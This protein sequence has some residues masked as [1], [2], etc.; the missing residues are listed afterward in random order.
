M[1]LLVILL[2]IITFSSAH[3]INLF[4][5]TL[6]NKL[7]IY[8]Y[9]ANGSPCKNCSF[10]IKNKEKIVFQNTLNDKGIYLYTPK[11]EKIEITIDANSGHITKQTVV[12]DNIKHEDIKKQQNK[13]EK[14]K[15]FK[16]LIGLILIF[17]LFFLLKRFKK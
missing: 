4:V 2:F 13:E 10:T 7:E 12:V 5:T 8:S 6:D 16:I 3:K 14:D 9:F 15:Y 1:R 11:H 17:I